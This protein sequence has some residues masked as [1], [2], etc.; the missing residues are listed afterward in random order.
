[1][2]KVNDEV[3]DNFRRVFEHNQPELNNT[4]EIELNDLVQFEVDSLVLR[5]LRYLNMYATLDKTVNS[6][7]ISYLKKNFIIEEN[8]NLEPF[9]CH[10]FFPV[11]TDNENVL[12]GVLQV[13]RT[14]K[15]NTNK[16][17]GSKS[18]PELDINMFADFYNYADF[19]E[20]MILY[21]GAKKPESGL[22]Y[23]FRSELFKHIIVDILECPENY[24]A[25]IERVAK[26]VKTAETE[27]RESK[28]YTR[29]YFAPCIDFPTPDLFNIYFD[30]LRAN[31]PNIELPATLINNY[32]TS[33]Y[34]GFE[35]NIEA[36]NRNIKE[37]RKCNKAASKSPYAFKYNKHS[38]A[39]EINMYSYTDSLK[40]IDVLDSDI[41]LFGILMSILKNFLHGMDI[42]AITS[43]TLN[44]MS[45]KNFNRSITY[46]F[47]TNPEETE[48]SLIR[49]LNYIAP[50]MENN[51]ER[52]ILILAVAINKIV[53]ENPDI[54]FD[55]DRLDPKIAAMFIKADM[56]Q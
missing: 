3:M 8:L 10:Y 4:S 5:S 56:Q 42:D 27:M 20:H 47:K 14:F 41:S 21:Y 26:I 30:V 19:L 55:V 34:N 32:K 36:Y 22:R 39:D 28:L 17:K 2:I 16:I 40:W 51:Y 12:C 9:Y 54:K 38:L 6:K 18:E 50:K 15:D 1:M 43:N 33:A 45:L 11:K 13:L 49:A 25:K 31:D 52:E 44:N 46:A 23:F 35:F 48:A 7:L 29:K 24:D 37:L 53:N